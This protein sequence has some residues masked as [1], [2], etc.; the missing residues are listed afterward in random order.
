[1]RSAK[2]KVGAGEIHAKRVKLTRQRSDAW[3]G[4]SVFG[5]KPEHC[6]SKRTLPRVASVVLNEIRRSQQQRN[7]N[8]L[9]V[10]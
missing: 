7:S 9:R 5:R 10:V 8:Q 1:M 4:R 6:A 3:R 2:S